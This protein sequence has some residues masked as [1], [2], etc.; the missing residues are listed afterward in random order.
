MCAPLP[1]FKAL[2]NSKRELRLICA[3]LSSVANYYC[4]WQ[5]AAYMSGG[6]RGGVRRGGGGGH[7]A[8]AGTN[9]QA[10]HS[11]VLLSAA[12]MAISR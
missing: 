3:G 6:G 12:A 4:S 8:G 1:K 11:I 2:S 9:I 7:E 10:L 5:P